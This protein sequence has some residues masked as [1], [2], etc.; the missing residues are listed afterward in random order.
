MKRSEAR[1]EP[2]PRKRLEKPLPRPSRA[3]SS[4]AMSAAPG[5]PAGGGSGFI[6]S[7]QGS[8]WPP[9][10]GPLA[11]NNRIGS[12]T[13]SGSAPGA[14]MSN[15][16]MPGAMPMIVH[17]PLA[18]VCSENVRWPANVPAADP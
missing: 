3:A 1:K 2:P 7:C 14:T 12:A 15:S 5:A 16:Q 6:T 10:F 18:L 8:S 9:A 11:V 17:S 13:A 4:A